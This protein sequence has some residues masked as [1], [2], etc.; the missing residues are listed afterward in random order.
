MNNIPVT[1]VAVS[2]DIFLAFI[3]SSPVVPM[4]SGAQPDRSLEHPT[5]AGHDLGRPSITTTVSGTDNAAQCPKTLSPR[6][7]PVN[8]PR[9]VQAQHVRGN[10]AHPIG[11]CLRKR[12]QD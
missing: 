11:T 9:A 6:S 2:R 1:M 4:L 8:F 5:F 12:Q 3:A 7:I 10:S